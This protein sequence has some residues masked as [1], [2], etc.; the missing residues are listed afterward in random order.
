MCRKLLKFQVF[1]LSI[2]A[3]T[4]PSQLL[5][6]SLIIPNF[7]NP[8]LTLPMTKMLESLVAKL[9][10]VLSLTCTTSK[11]P[12]CFSLLVITPIRPKLAPPVT[13]QT[14][15]IYTGKGNRDG[16]LK[17][18]N[19]KRKTKFKTFCSLTCLKL[20]EICDFACVQVNADGV[21][22]LDK[23]IRVT[24]GAGIMGH[25]MW[26]SLCANEDFPH[27]AQFVL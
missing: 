3:H 5:A 16:Q 23:R 6:N 25:Q 27:L 19:K 8:V 2:T 14:L 22:D 7:L 24:D 20:D 1:L 13:M 12:G 4:K 9:F 11:E 15:P 18:K 26:D 21:V 10:P 17:H